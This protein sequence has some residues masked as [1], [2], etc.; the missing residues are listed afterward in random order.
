MTQIFTNSNGNI[1]VNSTANILNTDYKISS[2]SGLTLWLE[3]SKKN[4]KLDINNKIIQWNDISG[5]MNHATQTND[6][7]K[8]LYE[9][10]I[11]NG[12]NSIRFNSNKYL[13]SLLTLNY[14][15]IFTIYK[16]SNSQYVYEYGNDTNNSTGFY[17]SGDLNT[18]SVNKSG[19]K[20]Y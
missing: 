6:S 19:N 4:I 16:S 17:L 5:N 1:L 12:Y 10:G 11:L 9:T 15:T 3:S 18:I 13:S 14:F 2:I 8:P 20:S 7:Y